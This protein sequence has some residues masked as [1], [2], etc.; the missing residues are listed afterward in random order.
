MDS[1]LVECHAGY[2]YAER[3]TALLWDDKRLEVIDII[4]SKRTPE[5]RFF[6][7]RTEE[8][9]AF[10]LSYDELSDEWSVNQV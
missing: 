4:E 5:G 10:T 2:T 3:P 7:V 9:K 8:N 6:R 1:E